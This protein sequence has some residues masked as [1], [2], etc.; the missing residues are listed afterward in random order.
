VHAQTRTK[1]DDLP[2][3]GPVVDVPDQGPDPLDKHGVPVAPPG[4][5]PGLSIRR[6][7]ELA[8]WYSNETHRRYNDGTLDVPE[9]DAE[10]RATLREEVDLLEHVEIEFKRVMDVVF[11]V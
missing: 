11:A 4:T 9:L 3:T 6:I 7:Q 2:Y 10:L 8:D 5:E 1:S